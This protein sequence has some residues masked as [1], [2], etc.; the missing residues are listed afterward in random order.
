MCVSVW[1]RGK[2]AERYRTKVLREVDVGTFRE[3][4]KTTF[5]EYLDLWLEDAVKPSVRQNTFDQYSW[6][7][8]RYVRPTL[9]AFRLDQVKPIHLQELYRSMQRDRKLSATT[10]R[11]THR[12]VNAAF[13]QAV[14]WN[15]LPDNPA[16]RVT[17]PRKERSNKRSLTVEEARRFL[18]AASGSRFEALFLVALYCGLRPSEYL[19]LRWSDL[20]LRQSRLTVSRRLVR[21]REGWDFDIPKT[22]RPRTIPLPDQVKKALQ[23]H[24]WRQNEERKAAGDAWEENDLAFCA[25]TGG[26]YLHR[27]LD[28]RHFKPLLRKAGLDE[29]LTLYEL[30]HSAGS[31]LLAAGANLKVIQELL[32]HNSISTT[33]DIYTH[34]EPQLLRDA[35]TSLESKLQGHEA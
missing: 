19:G 25:N 23:A 27:N 24:R 35:L 2:D 16:R 9:G 7:L 6:Q 14:R 29:S 8:R 30:R 17:L 11:L 32:G 31:L 21:T 1:K 12:V 33:M 5:D 13:T 34:P 18:Q 4:S 3:P 22:G 26:P 20:D 28:H 10:V 15:L